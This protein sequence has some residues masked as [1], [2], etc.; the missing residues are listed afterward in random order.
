MI[1]D[2]I[3]HKY[4]RHLRDIDQRSVVHLDT[5]ELAM[6]LALEELAA[7]TPSIP[8]MPLLQ[9]A[10]YDALAEQ[11]H[12]LTAQLGTAKLRIMELEADLSACREAATW[13]VQQ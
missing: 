5:I 7:S 2:T 6:R 11:V 9:T 1:A 10:G 3:L 8:S 12:D 13:T 4:V